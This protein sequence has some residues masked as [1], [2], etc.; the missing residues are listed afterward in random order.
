MS[1][2]ATVLNDQG[3]QLPRAAFDAT[4]LRRAAGQFASGVTVVTVEAQGGTHGMTANSFVSVSLDPPLV[5]VSVANRARMLDLLVGAGRF[6]ISV[7]SED[8]RPISQQFS[9]RGAAGLQVPLAKLG[10]VPVVPNAIGGFACR[11]HSRFPGGDHTLILGEVLELERRA[12]DPLLFFGGYYRAVRKIDD[13][14]VYAS[15]F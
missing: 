1:D 12:G 3:M 14:L 6:G 11:L 4:Q 5:L 10:G 9:G 15:M 7:L 8:Q 2:T 13:E